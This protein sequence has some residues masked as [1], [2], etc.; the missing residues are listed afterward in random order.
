M[1]KMP[2]PTIGAS[3][4][5][6]TTIGVGQRQNRNLTIKVR[7]VC[8]TTKDVLFGHL[9]RGASRSCGCQANPTIR[10]KRTIHGYC[11]HRLPDG[12]RTAR[13]TE[14]RIWQSMIQRCTNPKRNCYARYGGSGIRV[15]EEWLNSFPAFLD[16]MGRRPSMRRTLDRIDPYGNYEPSNTRWATWEQQRANQRRIKIGK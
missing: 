13:S 1:P 4:G 9:R 6:W 10:A 3:F 8:G 2:P 7:C 12:S 15:C 14:Y 16:H 5:Y 11:G